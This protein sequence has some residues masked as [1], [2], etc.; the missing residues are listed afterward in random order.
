MGEGRFEGLVIDKE[1]VEKVAKK[2]A[3]K[4]T[5]IVSA[6]IFVLLILPIATIGTIPG[7]Y[8]LLVPC[9]MSIMMFFVMYK[10]FKFAFIEDEERL[11]SKDFVE[12]I[13]SSEDKTEVVPINASEHKEFLLQLT[14]IAKYYAI[15]NQE[16]GNIDVYVKFNSENE[17]RYLET[18]KT[19]FFMNYY[20][21]PIKEEI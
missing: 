17:M 8:I 18:Q 7:L 15:I 14:D 11:I 6:I 19:D 21:I 2:K 16:T 4:L 9:I 20:S 5:L 3:A 1:Q 12:K 13:F 10:L